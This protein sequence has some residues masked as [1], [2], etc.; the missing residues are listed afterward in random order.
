MTSNGEE[1]VMAAPAVAWFEVTGQDG[2]AL[3]R[4]YSALFDWQVQDSGDGSGYGLV[5]AAPG[6]IGGGVGR[7]QDGGSGGVTFYVEVDDPA[8]YLKKAEALGGTT[9]VEPT[10][11]P[12][13]GLT[14]AFLSDPEGHVVGLIKGALQ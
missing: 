7:A 13:F 5:S 10:E 9:V 2:P 12:G 11:I 14:F 8:D 1:K 4:F 3:Q 6:G